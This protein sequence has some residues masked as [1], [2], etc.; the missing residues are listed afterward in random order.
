[1]DTVSLLWRR[2]LAPPARR[3]RPPKL[4][5]DTVVD[6]GIAV[7]DRVGPQFSLREVAD[8]LGVAVMVLYSYVTGRD[9]LLDLMVD[10][11]RYAMAHTEPSGGWRAR[12]TRVAQDNLALFDQHPWLA[13]IESERAVLGPGT[14]AKYERELD[15]VEALPVPD[16]TKDAALALVLDFVRASARSLWQARAERA[17]EP[18]AQWWQREGVRFAELGVADRYPLAHRIGSAAGA[19]HGA[20]ADAEHAYTFGLRL[21]LD[22][23]AARLS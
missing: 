18:P 3:G 21:I 16:V 1:M 22:G 14:L 8:E 10:E 20:A 13:H 15:A 5:V 2:E 17:Q 4:H 12:L 6:A 7:A 9:Q 19:A 11:C 23:I